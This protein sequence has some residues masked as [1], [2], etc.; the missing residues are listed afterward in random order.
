MRRVSASAYAGLVV[1]LLLL[2]ASINAGQAQ[3]AQTAAAT[4]PLAAANESYVYCWSNGVGPVFYASDVFAA[5]WKTPQE[6]DGVKAAFLAFLQKKYGFKSDSNHFVECYAVDPSPGAF[7]SVKLNKRYA[8][9]T[10]TANKQQIVETGWMNTSAERSATYTAAQVVANNAPVN[11]AVTSAA[12]TASAAAAAYEN[13]MVC[14]STG[15]PVAYF[16]DVF[17]APP[18]PPGP[19]GRQGTQLGQT[20]LAF[21]KQKYALTPNDHTICSGPPTPSLQKAEAYKQQME[22]QTKKANK[23]VV[24]TGWKN[25]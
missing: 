8:T 21:L 3:H 6:A 10:A 4:A 19:R 1:A 23:Q 9:E 7:R 16:S 24:E 2:S 20:F 15:E 18:P 12:A 11:A 5:L 22:D 13:Y 14:W 25:Q 17:N